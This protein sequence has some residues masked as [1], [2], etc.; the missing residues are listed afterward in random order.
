MQIGISTR[1][2]RCDLDLLGATGLDD[3]WRCVEPRARRGRVARRSVTIE[4]VYVIAIV[5]GM[6]RD[7]PKV[8]G[9][10]STPLDGARRAVDSALSPYDSR[11]FDLCPSL[12]SRC[13]SGAERLPWEQEVGGA[14][15]LT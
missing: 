6:G 13:S 14:I 5:P 2:S 7:S 4:C 12:L 1:R 8:D 9:R 10:G 3:V 11:R 15:P